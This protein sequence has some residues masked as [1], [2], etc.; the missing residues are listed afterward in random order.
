MDH[1]VVSR[2]VVGV[3][4]SEDM[5]E[6]GIGQLPD[7]AVGCQHEIRIATD[8]DAM[9]HQSANTVLQH[10]KAR[11]RLAARQ[12][13][14]EYARFDEK[15]EQSVESSWGQRL[16]PV[17]LLAPEVVAVPA[18]DVADIGDLEVNYRRC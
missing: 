18:L 9:P 15:F 2:R 1:I 14:M 3:E 12:H 8:R 11:E 4:A 6:S 17:V 13:D 7:I 5:V 16:L 10:I